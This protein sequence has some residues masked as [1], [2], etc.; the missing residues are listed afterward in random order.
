MAHGATVLAD[1][2]IEITSAIVRTSLTLRLVH[3]TFD[4]FLLLPS[5]FRFQ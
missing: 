3:V 2:L 1:V 4:P 5:F